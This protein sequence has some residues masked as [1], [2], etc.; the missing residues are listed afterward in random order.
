MGQPTKMRFTF[1]AADPK[2]LKF[3]DERAVKGGPWMVGETATFKKG[4]P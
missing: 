2:A 1:D 3:T 4:A